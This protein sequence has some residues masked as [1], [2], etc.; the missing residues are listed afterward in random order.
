LVLK[1][2]QDDSLHPS[3]GPSAAVGTRHWKCLEILNM[4][5]VSSGAEKSGL[6]TAV[7]VLE[8]FAAVARA[9][10]VAANSGVRVLGNRGRGHVSGLFHDVGCRTSISKFTNHG[11]HVRLG[12]TE[13][14]LVPGTQVVKSVFAVRGFDEPLFGASAVAGEFEFAFSAVVRESV[15][16]V[17]PEFPLLRAFS[18]LTDGRISDVSEV[19]FGVNEVVA[20]IN[21][22]VVL[23]DHRVTASLGEDA[24]TGVLSHP[25]GE[26]RVEDLY[27]IFSDVFA[28]PLVE[29]TVEELSV[30]L[31]TN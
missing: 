16:F 7:A 21:V 30:L 11:L 2:V 15:S 17:G 4:R 25:T 31:R 23:D 26:S 14:G 13:E 28:Y 3:R 10:F 6:R 9:W 12:V 29:N 8:F 22:A 20:R 24:Q 18:H 19:V 27:E 1:R 5:R